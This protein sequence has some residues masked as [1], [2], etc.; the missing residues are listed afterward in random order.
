LSE[1]DAGTMQAK[2]RKSKRRRKTMIKKRNKGRSKTKKKTKRKK[3]RRKT[4]KKKRRKGKKGYDYDSNDTSSD[5]SHPS[6][7]EEPEEK[8]Y[9]NSMI[10]REC[11]REPRPR[12]LTVVDPDHP[13][14]FFE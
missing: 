14:E 4:Y 3:G 6:S 11:K 1:S 10:F 8:V 9:A 13:I 2:S 12:S 7:I 5:Q